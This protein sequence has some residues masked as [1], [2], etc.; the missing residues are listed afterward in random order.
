MKR[1]KVSSTRRLQIA[2]RQE[3]KCA[4]CHKL[5]PWRFQIDHMVP[6]HRGGSNGIANLQALCGTCHDLKSGHE[7]EIR[8]DIEREKRTGISKY[9]DP[10][11]ASYI[12][13]D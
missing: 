1:I 7:F 13:D 11:S 5:L 9:F 6:L 12:A 2:C 10:L 8:N 3:Y 4:H